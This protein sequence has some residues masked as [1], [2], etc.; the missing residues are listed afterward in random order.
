MREVSIEEP[1]G[2]GKGERSRRVMRVFL[3]EGRVARD[4]AVER[5]KTPEPIMRIEDGK[6]GEEAIGMV[7]K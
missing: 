6:E 4:R 3:K 1:S 2:E 5:P 7:R